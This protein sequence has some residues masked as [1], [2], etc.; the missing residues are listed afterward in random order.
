M[1]SAAQEGDKGIPGQSPVYFPELQTK[2]G[3]EI[4]RRIRH[5]IETGKALPLAEA[6]SPKS[7]TKR[8][9]FQPDP[10][11]RK[12]IEDSAMRIVTD[13]FNALGYKVDDVS[14]TKLGYDLVAVQG[15][16]ALCIEVKGRSGS[17]VVADFTFNEFDKIRLEE[18]G[19]FLEGSYRICIVTDALGERASPK[20]HHFWCVT[21]RGASN[22]TS[23]QRAWQNIDGKGTL[24]LT[25]REAAQGRIR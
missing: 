21:P 5:F 9:R 18:R 14:A 16:A 12:E 17:E 8:N 3:L 1:D 25:P 4:A 22:T 23:R 11:R 19:R 13:H 7:G 20:L 24:E 6:V 15:D 2:V 10:E